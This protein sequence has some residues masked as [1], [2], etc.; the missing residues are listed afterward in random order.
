MAVMLVQISKTISTV[1][2]LVLFLIGLSGVTSLFLQPI[3]QISFLLTPLEVP[4]FYN[5]LYWQALILV[6]IWL[7]IFYF[8]RI[9]ATIAIALISGKWL[10]LNGLIVF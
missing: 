4:A 6:G 7:T 3:E 9:A 8:A 10:M 1:V 5:Q 2:G